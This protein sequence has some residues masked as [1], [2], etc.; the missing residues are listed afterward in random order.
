M[1]KTIFITVGILILVLVVGVWAYLFTFGTPKSS[2][3]IFARFGAGND[4]EIT[5]LP[6]NTNIDVSNTDA[7]GAPQ[8][9]K[10][11]TTRPVAGA[12]F[13][14]NTI[15][16]VEQGTGHIYVIDLESGAETLLSGTT[17]PGA[18]NAV[19]SEDGLYTAV[20]MLN[21]GNE[22]TLVGKLSLGTQFSGVSLPA[23][24]KN[25]A[26]VNASGT[27]EY[28]ITDGFN[29]QGYS[30]NMLKEVDT[31]VFELPLKD[32]EV[33]WGNPTYVYTTPTTK[34]LGYL[35]Q[36]VKNNLHF[37][38]E[39]DRGLMSF[40]THDGVMVTRVTDALVKSFLITSDGQRIAQP[41]PYIPEKCTS[42]KMFLYCA[43]PKNTLN[44]HAFPDDWYMG[45]VSFD[46]SLWTID[47]QNQKASVLIDFTD[48]SGRAMDVLKIGADTEGKK[49]YLINKNDNTLWLFDTT[50]AGV[51]SPNTGREEG[52]M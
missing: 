15:R 30:Y 36:V 10:Q 16:Y 34:Q 3:E 25:V 23:G 40:V 21:E 35:Y 29:T 49:V 44:T 38:T 26:F 33:L 14:G 43:I 2:N 4:A 37:V 51:P 12:G 9:L 52:G 5:T 1:K 27:L 41:L 48:T 46:D 6:E 13:S 39:G 32:I 17:I 42:G 31:K 50:L 47:T 28:T 11:L 7:V 8:I 22:K 19:F 45:T 20:T 18:R 24:A